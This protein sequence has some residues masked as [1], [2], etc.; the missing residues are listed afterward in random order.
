AVETLRPRTA[1]HAL[2]QLWHQAKGGQKIPLNIRPN[3]VKFLNGPADEDGKQPIAGRV[4]EDRVARSAIDFYAIAMGNVTPVGE[5]PAGEGGRCL[6]DRRL[7][8]AGE[9]GVPPVGPDCEARPFSG[10]RA[11]PYGPAADPRQPVAVA[12]EIV[13]HEPRPQL[14]ASL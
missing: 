11:A 3:P 4:G 5:V 6:V 13:D 8:G 9:A 7:D 12:H 1:A 2:R 14:D 10:H